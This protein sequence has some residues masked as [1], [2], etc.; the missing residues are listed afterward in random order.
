MVMAWAAT[1]DD[2]YRHLGMPF[3]GRSRAYAEYDEMRVCVIEPQGL[4]SLPLTNRC[5]TEETKS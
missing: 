3:Y 1:T 5:R 4:L 2:M